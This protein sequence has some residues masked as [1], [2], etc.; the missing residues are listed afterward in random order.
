VG[1]DQWPLTWH[2]DNNLYGAW[3]DGYGIDANLPNKCYLGITRITGS[4]SSFSGQDLYCHE[5]TS[6]PN[7]KPGAGPYSIGNTLYLFYG[8]YDYPTDTM[9]ATSTNN[10]A[11][12][13][14]GTKVFD[15]TGDEAEMTGLVHFGPGHTDVP[16]H[17]DDNY[18]YALFTDA[19]LNTD[20]TKP[21]YLARGLASA[22]TI[23]KNWQWFI[24]TNASGEARWGSRENAQK[25]VEDAA[26]G[27]TGERSGPSWFQTIMTYNP[28]LGQYI[29]T[30]FTD[31]QGNL[32][33]LVG[34]RPWGPFTKIWNKDFK[35]S[36]RKFTI[37]VIPKFISSDGKTVW[38][39]WSGAP[40]YDEVRFLRA[41]LKVQP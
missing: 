20:V 29:L 32:Q 40:T 41:T 25:I 33:V 5:T 12:W 15:G 19:T 39:A 10:G 3:G 30:Y 6:S 1:A 14:F 34:D 11:D 22:P 7:R 18:M 35:N 38:V 31:R 21:L 8:D 37:M 16:A 9:A 24:G 26:T 23:K 28:P 36:E 27:N 17:L 2:S 13:S 4:A